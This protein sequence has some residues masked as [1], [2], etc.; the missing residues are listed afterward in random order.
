MMALMASSMVNWEGRI[1]SFGRKRR[2]PFGG[3][4]AVGTKTVTLV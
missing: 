4:K 1:F 2:K 3:M